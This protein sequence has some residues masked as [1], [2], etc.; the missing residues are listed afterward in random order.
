MSRVNNEDC[1]VSE[2]LVK[3]TLE[4]VTK[5]QTGSRYIAL[6]FP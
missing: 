6:L 5:P 2:L 1:R 4:Q 3:L